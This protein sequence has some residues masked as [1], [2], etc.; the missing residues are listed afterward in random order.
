MAL[1][2]SEVDAIAAAAEI[3]GK[4]VAEAFM[5]RSH[6][7]TLRVREI[8]SNG[9]LGELRMVRGSFTFMPAKPDDY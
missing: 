7:Q 2:T 1:T 3:Y 8:V 4:V 9:K 5:Y 6:P